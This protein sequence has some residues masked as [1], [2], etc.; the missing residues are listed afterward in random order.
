M[1]TQAPVLG[2]AVL[3]GPAPRGNSATS[4][5]SAASPSLKPPPAH[6]RR[7]PCRAD[8]DGPERPLPS[9]RSCFPSYDNYTFDS[10]S[11]TPTNRSFPKPYSFDASNEATRKDFAYVWPRL[12]EDGVPRQKTVVFAGGCGRAPTQTP[13]RESLNAAAAHTFPSSAGPLCISSLEDALSNIRLG[14]DVEARDVER[15]KPSK[16]KKDLVPPP[17]GLHD[18]C[19]QEKPTASTTFATCHRPPQTSLTGNPNEHPD[20][21][22][23]NNNEDDC[24]EPATDDEDGQHDGEGEEDYD[25][26]NPGEN[27]DGHEEDDEEGQSGVDDIASNTKTKPSLNAH[28]GCPYRK[29]NP[30]HFNVREHSKCAKPFKDLSSVKSVR[31]FGR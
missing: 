4:S 10:P 17:L 3:H 22:L 23:E 31:N 21:S 20:A 16:S 12:P 13:P 24:E 15:L 11:Q 14:Q 19:Q 5:C 18:A 28:L 6:T 25:W 8:Q 26:Q 29:R 7:P 1:D 30:E 2:A 27:D 9:D